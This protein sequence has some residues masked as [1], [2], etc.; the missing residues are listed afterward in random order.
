MLALTFVH[1]EIGQEKKYYT[2]RAV[3]TVF[4]KGSMRCMALEKKACQMVRDEH[5]ECVLMV[6]II[7]RI[8]CEQ[9]ETHQMGD[10]TTTHHL[11]RCDILYDHH[12]TINTIAM[13]TQTPT[14]HQQ[15]QK[16]TTSTPADPRVSQRQYKQLSRFALRRQ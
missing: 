16:P 7:K 14:H 12:R 9:P 6:P 4:S 2:N 8:K 1:G 5:T 15:Q 10:T 13:V 11:D 3:Y